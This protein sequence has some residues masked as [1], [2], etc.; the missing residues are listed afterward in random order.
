M[1]I[2]IGGRRSGK[3]T[4]L[5]N[6]VVEG[7]ESYRD[8]E[9]EFRIAVVGTELL[10]KELLGRVR[11]AVPGLHTPGH[12][13][14]TY[15]T[16][17]QGHFRGRDNFRFGLDDY[18]P[19]LSRVRDALLPMGIGMITIQSPVDLDGHD[20]HLL[21]VDELPTYGDFPMNVGETLTPGGSIG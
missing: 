5:L 20:V 18:R 14:V 9:D 11:S 6:W 17:S 2:I 15:G 19:D 3:T 10:R 16:V 7:L 13:V 4:A 12:T 21:G 1:E 8:P